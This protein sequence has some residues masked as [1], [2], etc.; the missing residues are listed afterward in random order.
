MNGTNFGT[1]INKLCGQGQDEKNVL[2]SFIPH[3]SSLVMR[4]RLVIIITLIVV[5]GVLVLLNAA[6][7]VN[8]GP[9]ADSE[10]TPDRSSFNA[11]PTGTRALYDFLHE[12]GYQVARWREST[13]SLLSFNGP[14]PATIVVIGETRIPFTKTESKELLRWVETGGRLVVIDRSPDEK[15]L[16]ASGEWTIKTHMTSFPWPGLNP[17]DFEQMTREVKPLPP[18]Q[19]TLMARDVEKI[20]PSRFAG[21]ITVVPRYRTKAGG[22]SGGGSSQDNAAGGNS[23]EPADDSESDAEPTP[24]AEEASATV[25]KGPKVSPAPVTN[26]SDERG[27]LLVDYPHGKGRIVLLSDPFIV[28]NNGINRADNLQLAINIVV[29]NG[30]VVAFDEFHQGRAATHNALIQYFEGTPVV[31]ICG[32]LALLGLAIVWSR[33]TR[34]ARP[35][36]LPQ[37]DRRSSLEFVASMAELQQRAKAHDLALEN[38]YGRVRRVLVRYAGMNNSSPRVEIARRVAARSGL[39]QKQL[40]SLMRSCEDTINGAPTNAK[41]TLRLVKRLR[42]L[43]ATLGLRGRARDVKQEKDDL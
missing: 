3:P 20:L 34:F 42:Q 30:G 4:Q 5:V 16:P 32:Q 14:K 15:I 9:T 26:F 25:D 13:A 19:P 39:N 37:V 36:P 18:S 1:G 35:L 17:T 41:E 2:S 10:A 38:I 33:G 11:G 40:E 27:T 12:S 28:A 43:E 21:A 7:Y 31:A 23:E 8:V 29:G 6:S 22:N 24:K